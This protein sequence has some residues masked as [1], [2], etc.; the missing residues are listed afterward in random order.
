LL[1]GEI[2]TPMILTYVRGAK[3]KPF[4]LKNNQDENLLDIASFIFRAIAKE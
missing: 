2:V 1:R 4:T 3:N